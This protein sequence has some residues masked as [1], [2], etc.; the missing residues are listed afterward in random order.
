LREIGDSRKEIS[1]GTLFRGPKKFKRNPT[2]W[3]LR[4]KKRWQTSERGRWG[5]PDEMDLK[6]T[7]D[8]V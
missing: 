7:K 3:N 2:Q 6:Q 4:G 8:T 1:E 5:L